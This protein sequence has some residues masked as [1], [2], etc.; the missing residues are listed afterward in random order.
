MEDI[1]EFVFDEFIK[2]K[3]AVVKRDIKEFAY[4][5]KHNC[6]DDYWIIMNDF[7]LEQQKEYFKTCQ[8]IVGQD[9]A[10]LKNISVLIV[11]EV[12]NIGVDE[13]QWCIDL[14]NNP[15]FFKKYGLVYTM[16][17]WSK[18]KKLFNSMPDDSF[19][20]I[21]MKP[22]LFSQYKDGDN[23]EIALMYSIAHK[24]PFIMI[25]TPGMTLDIPTEYGMNESQKDGLRWLDS[26]AEVNLDKMITASLKR[27]KDE[28]IKN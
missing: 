15:F 6:H 21:I 10:S 14:E 20:S 19:T 2:A 5:L 8:N 12:E 25:E 13:R 16:D 18:L 17:A 9:P 23:D 7:D 24:M 1:L 27:I 22:E 4:I 26:I 11:K 28:H 3:Y